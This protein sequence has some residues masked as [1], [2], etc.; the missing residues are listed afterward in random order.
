MPGHHI[1]KLLGRAGRLAA[2]LSGSPGERAKIIR[3]F[4][5]A[6]I[7]D[8][9]TLTIRIWRGPLL[10]RNVR[11]CASA[12]AR[13]ESLRCSLPATA[14]AGSRRGRARRAASLAGRSRH[15]P[16]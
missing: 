4:V 2:A 11:S 5:E 15:Q 8:D 7:V 16:L 1:R 10:D 9:T 3:G 12:E 14:C 13:R 6:V